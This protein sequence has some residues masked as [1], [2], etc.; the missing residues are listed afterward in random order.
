MFK[1]RF[2]K[3]VSVFTCA[4][5]IISGSSIAFATDSIP[6]ADQSADPVVEAAQ[7]SGTGSVEEEVS[8]DEGVTVPVIDEDAVAVVGEETEGETEEP[9]EFDKYT[10]VEGHWA[11]D[12]LKRAFEDGILNGFDDNKM[13]PDD[14]ITG[15]QMITIIT[16]VLNTSVKA[17]TSNIYFHDG[18]W[19]HDQVAEAIALGIMDASDV[20]SLDGKMMRKDAMS[21]MSDAFQLEKAEPDMEKA[22]TYS[23]F[24]VLPYDEKFLFASLVEQGYLQGWDGNLH[25]NADITRAEFVTLLYRVAGEYLKAE[26]VADY[27]AISGPAVISGEKVDFK[28]DNLKANIWLDTSVKDIAFQGTDAK[29]VYVRSDSVSSLKIKSSDIERLVLATRGGDTNFDCQGVDTTVVGDGTGNVHLSPSGNDVEVI[30]DGRNIT[31]DERTGSL[32]VSGN[33]NTIVLKSSADASTVKIYGKNNTVTVDSDVKN[34]YVEGKNNTVAGKGKASNAS[35]S[36][37]TSKIDIKVG[38]LID[39]ID[40]G[41]KD[42]TVAVTAPSQ[43]EAGKNLQATASFT[44]IP[45]GKVVEVSWTVDGEPVMTHTLKMEEGITSQLD[46]KY[47]YYWNMPDYAKVV[48]TVKYTT[49]DGEAQSVSSPET[50]VSVDKS[51]A[52]YYEAVVASIPTYYKGNFTTQ[53]AID[54]NLS[55]E[56][57]EIFVNYKGYSSSSKYLIWVNIGTQYTSVFEGSK[58]NWKLIRSGLVSTGAGDCTPRGVFKTTYKQTNWTTS[59]YTVKP[60]VR[61]YGGGYAMHSRLYKPNTTTLKGGANGVGYPL[62]HGC[63]RMQ[64]DDIQWVYDNVPSGTT[65]VC[66]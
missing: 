1:K 23:D 62:S 35:I 24:L 60:V 55:D 2:L 36:T 6:A 59:S 48:C 18:T 44:N 65:I 4:A 26:E 56:V 19:Y 42:M 25:L 43:V 50:A 20:P 46:H 33:N 51:S 28:N 7:D 57:K 11:K 58:G 13:R 38:N 21:M 22:D 16:R 34:L 49:Y 39:N 29:N 54:H 15:A 10:D 45:V 17:D 5:M 64:A 12:V 37:I 30:C 61:F 52:E 40:Y 66:Y 32:I 14:K 27:S 41:I 31:L 47:S 63:V 8:V 3:A 9:S 53:W